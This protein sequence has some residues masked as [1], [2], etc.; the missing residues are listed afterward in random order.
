MA[1]EETSIGKTFELPE[2]CQCGNNQFQYLD[3]GDL[4][5]QFRCLK[6]GQLVLGRQDVRS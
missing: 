5:P 3:V 1:T 2:N 4:G 6:C